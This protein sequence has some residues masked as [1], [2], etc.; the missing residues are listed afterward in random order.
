MEQ[1]IMY[2]A[3][4]VASVDMGRVEAVYQTLEPC[5]VQAE[6]YQA[7]GFTAACIP[8]NQPE[9]IKSDEQLRNLAQLFYGNANRTSSQ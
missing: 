6:R 9:V 1:F 7:M 5:Q 3:L 2:W 4:V 8:T